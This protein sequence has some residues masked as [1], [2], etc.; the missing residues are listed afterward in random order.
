MQLH[1]RRA[2]AGFASSPVRVFREGNRHR[3]REVCSHSIIFPADDVQYRSAPGN[4]HF[5]NYSVDGERGL[6]AS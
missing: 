6:K 2:S 3:T 4:Q 5:R 1:F